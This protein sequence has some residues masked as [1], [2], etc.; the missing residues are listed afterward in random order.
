V[1]AYN[2]FFH[3]RENGPI[4][5]PCIQENNDFETLGWQNYANLH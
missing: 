1:N 3:E 2:A 5:I 4:C